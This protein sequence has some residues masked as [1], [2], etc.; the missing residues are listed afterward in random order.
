VLFTFVVEV[1]LP[2]A[3]LGPRRWR[4]VACAG[5]VALQVLIA[6]TGNYGFFNLLTVVLCVPLLEDSFF[7]ARWRAHLAPADPSAAPR[8]GR[9]WP[10]W[11]VG[12]VTALVLVLS[13]VPFVARSGA[14]RHWPDWV[15]EAYRAAASFRSVNTYG[16]F[17]VM[18]THRPEI[19][20]EG[21]DDGTTWLPYEFRWKP[22]DVRR[23]PRFTGPHLPRLDWQMWFAAL[24]DYRENTWLL[25]FLVRLLDGSPDVLAL[26]E[27][28]PFPDHPPRFVRAVLYEYHFTDPAERSRTG[29]WWRRERLGLYCPVLSRRDEAGAANEAPPAARSNMR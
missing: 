27:R 28:N 15:V 4:L 6:A 9:G 24:G 16:L 23:R 21:S 13:V 10:A 12:P 25:H 20:V 22:G 29:A 14:V 17:A 7:P 3:I 5:I 1:L 19:I 26:L 8:R 2:L 18:T 11:V